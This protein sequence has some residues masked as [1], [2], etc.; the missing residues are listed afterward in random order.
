MK[1]SI[2]I[3]AAA[4]LFIAA[5]FGQSAQKIDEILKSGEATFGQA[6][7]LILTALGSASDDTDFAAAFDEI[8]KH[9][10]KWIH[11]SVTAEDSIPVKAYAFLLM[12]AF[13]ME[14]G[15]MYRIYPCP[16]YA[17][18]DLRYLAIIQG[19]DDPDAPMTGAEMLQILARIETVGGDKK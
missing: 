10:Q 15:M 19:K 14:R 13:N 9:D 4:C 16:R 5:A 12:N 8:R 1:Q 7:Y 2:C 3:A 11:N 6:A 17:F 18:R